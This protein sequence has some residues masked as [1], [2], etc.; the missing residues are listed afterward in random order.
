MANTIT[1]KSGLNSLTIEVAP[2]TTVADVLGNPNYAAALGYDPANVEGVLNGATA[3]GGATLYAGDILLA[4][5][6]AHSKAADISVTLKSGLNSLN[7][8]VAEGSSVESVLSNPNY[9][10]ALGY[11][12]A[13][14]EGILNG[15]TASG[16]ATL[17]SGDTLLAQKK[18]HSKAL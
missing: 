12:P 5:K 11:D 14:V 8:T 7:V 6:K 4:Q 2:G 15:A 10:A 1:L 13:S 9:A 17:Y 3:S 16:G 18:A